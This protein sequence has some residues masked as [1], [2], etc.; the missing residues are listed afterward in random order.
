MIR[1]PPRSTRTDTLFPYTTLFRSLLK[2]HDA[3]IIG[4]DIARDDAG[5]LARY[6]AVHSRLQ[7]AREDRSRID[8]IVA[9]ADHAR[10]S[11]ADSRGLFTIV[12]VGPRRTGPSVHFRGPGTSRGHAAVLAS[13][14]V[15]PRE[16]DPDRTPRSRKRRVG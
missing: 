6:G 4:V 1:R 9:V 11:G 10:R 15:F 3:A 16:R 8:Q 2:Q 5:R 13:A 14:P 12:H 7:R